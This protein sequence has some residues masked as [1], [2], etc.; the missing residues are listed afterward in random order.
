MVWGRNGP[1][2]IDIDATMAQLRSAV[3]NEPGKYRLYQCDEHAKEIEGATA[4]HVRV[5]P[6]PTWSGSSGPLSVIDDGSP[7]MTT[8][9]SPMMTARHSIAPM[10]TLAAEAIPGRVVAEI[11]HRCLDLFDRMLTSHESQ[12]ELLAKL[13]TTLVT[14]TAT[15][16][17]ST[18][19]LLGTANA[20]VKVANGIEAVERSSGAPAPQLG[21]DDLADK[22]TGIAKV[23]DALVSLDLAKSEPHWTVQ[24]LTGPAGG[25]LLA[26]ATQVAKNIG[27]AQA[28]QAARAAQP[29]S[30]TQN[31]E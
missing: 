9:T 25:N 23:H 20:T 12:H 16:Q 4:A 6:D 7:P 31:E 26:L 27:A 11:P 28:A 24:L 3:N 29:A 18:A 10:T 17:Q 30:A 15:I 1:V 8:T 22:V 2:R 13:V 14:S 19:G 21:F 5:V